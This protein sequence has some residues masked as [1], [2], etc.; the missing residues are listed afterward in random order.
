MSYEDKTPAD[1]VRGKALGPTEFPC[2][3]E[4]SIPAASGTSEVIRYCVVKGFGA[5]VW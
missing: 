5:H 4:E 1:L 2:F 3:I